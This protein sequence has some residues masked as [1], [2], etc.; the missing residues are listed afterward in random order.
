VVI[1]KK[2]LP[3]VLSCILYRTIINCLKH[4]RLERAK[5]LAPRGSDN[6]QNILAI[7]TAP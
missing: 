7:I 1:S 2:K 5:A 4:Q 3:L 6:E